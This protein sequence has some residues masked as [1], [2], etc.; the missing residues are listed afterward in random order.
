MSYPRLRRSRAHKFVHAT[1]TSTAIN[2]S[3]AW[4]NLSAS[5]ASFTNI[6][7]KEVQVGDLL[8]AWLSAFWSNEAETGY[9]DFATYTAGGAVINCFSSGTPTPASFGIRSGQGSPSVNT[10][11]SVLAHYEV[12][13]DDIVDGTV[14]VRPRVY[15]TGAKTLAHESGEWLL[16]NLGP[17][18]I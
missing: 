13:A 17:V 18:Q 12:S 7:L 11:I 3:S 10:P 9:I 6:T 14:I 4:A 2:T 8:E 1:G 16:N 5:V 15:T